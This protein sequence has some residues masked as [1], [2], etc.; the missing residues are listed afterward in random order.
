MRISELKNKTQRLRIDSSDIFMGRRSAIVPTPFLVAMK[1]VS[2][3]PARKTVLTSKWLVIR[4][5]TASNGFLENTKKSKEVLAFSAQSMAE[6]NRQADIPLA[7][8]SKL[9]CGMLMN[10]PVRLRQ[11]Y[12]SESANVAFL[13]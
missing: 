2:K 12:S 7:M 11:R 13:I 10:L 3:S 4:H 1:K 6:K 5:F 9:R 8:H